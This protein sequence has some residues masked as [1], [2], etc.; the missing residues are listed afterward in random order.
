M[1][2]VWGLVCLGLLTL[3]PAELG[4]TAQQFQGLC[5]LVK[6]E[7][8]QELTLERIGFLATLEVTNNEGDAAITNFSAQLTFE[9]F[10]GGG[11]DASELFFVQPP[12]LQGINAIDGSGI[13]HPGE[14]A[15]VRWFIIPKIDAG[16]VTPLG[17]RY[18]VG[19]LLAGSIY[20]QEIAPEVLQVFPDIITVKPEPQLEI[21]YF[22]PRDVD[23]DDPFTTDVVEAPIPFTLGV[24]VNNVGFGRANDVKIASEQPKIVEN[25]QSLI[26]VAQLLGARVDDQP[27]DQTSLTLNLGDIESGNC[28]K[29]A[30]DMITSLSGEFIEFNASYTH[31]SELGGRDTSIIKDLNAYFISHEVLNDQPGRDGLKDFLADTI[32]DDEILPDTLFET[33][34]TTLPV[35]P[36][37][38]V[39]L[40]GST[41]LTATV[42]AVADFEGWVYMRLDDPKQAR[43]PIASVVRSDGKVLNPNN[44]WTNVRFEKSTNIKLTFLNIFDF[45]ALGEYTYE[46]TYEVPPADVDPP[47]TFLRFVGDVEER[48]GVFQIRPETQMYFTVEDASPVAIFY[49]FST[50]PDFLP[51]LPFFLAVPG[52]YEIEYF[53]IDAA[54]NE[55]GH[56]FA[57]L[58][59]S[60]VFPSVGNLALDTSQFFF[61]GDSVS[62]RSKEAVV[63]FD[64]G[65]PA[66]TVNGLIEVF[67]GVFGYATIEGV[68]SSPT[69]R[70]D[71]TIT[72][73]GR[74]VDFYRYSLNGAPWTA[75]EP[76]ANP[77]ALSGLSG[78]VELRVKGRSRY[79]DYRPDAEAVTATWTIAA[80]ADPIRIAG[81]Q[82]PSGSAGATLVVTGTPLYCYRVDGGFY[83]P[84]SSPG[85]QIVLSELDEGSHV[86]EVRAR[87]S[88]GDPCP[89]DVPGIAFSWTID[90][91]Y[92]TDLPAGQRVREEFLADIGGAPVRFTWDGLDENGAHVPPDWYT[93]KV[94]VTDSLSRATSDV[95]LVRVGDLLADSTAVA[96]VPGADQREAHASGDW[97]VWQDQRDGD[98]NVFAL[99]LSDPAAT[100]VRVT[101]DARNQERPRTDGRYVVWEDR[102]A[103]GSWDI[104][105]DDL[106][107]ATPPFPV[108]TTATLDERRPSVDWPW[109]VFQRR[110]VADPTAPWQ[111]AYVNLAT[112]ATGSVDPTTQNQL[113][114]VVRDGRA[115]WEDYRD[116]GAG[117]IYLVDLPSGAVRRITQDPGG[118]IQP[119]IDDQWIVW[120][121]NR[122]GLQLDLYGFNLK[123]GVE[124][125]LTD[126][127]QDEARPAA[128]A[129]WVVYTDDL[130]DG[131]NVDLRLL[132]L[133][134]LAS[135]QLTNFESEK[136]KPS[137]ASG[138]L[139]WVDKRSGDER[140][141]VGS[142]PDLQPVFDNNS[143]VVVTADMAA[144]HGDAFSLLEL[145]QAEAGVTQL[146]RFTNLLPTPVS[147]TASWS[148]S[149]TGDNFP[150]VPGS[151]LWV[152]FGDSE[153]LDLGHESCGA[154]DLAAGISALSYT[155]FPDRYTA[156][157]AIRE[158]GIANVN[159]IRVLDSSTGRWTVA[160]VSA[161]NLIGE[162]F[163]IPRV[164]VVL[165]DL[166]AAR[167]QWTPG[168]GN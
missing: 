73:A 126:T 86:V 51:A 46:I 106:T 113:A 95:A 160:S 31:A 130:A 63:R 38:D 91:S 103:D 82:T 67:R 55:E 1:R 157:Q 120:A 37:V 24:L 104:W 13:I 108:T 6:I 138:R 168:E 136:Q 16:G 78:T 26:L 101:I 122:A 61:T 8:L 45:V 128:N 152:E 40:I 147:E 28:R 68:P 74:N 165:L 15:V 75:E 153:I 58:D 36:L 41:S 142:V 88:A 107:D 109:V 80:G 14:T 114:P 57:T 77:I 115:V 110:A 17:V 161:G 29:G 18:S 105:A 112:L 123:R 132:Y 34:C 76:V 124:V 121:D 133:P 99:N 81:P 96:G 20:G 32:D 56:K 79:G 140:V 163:T 27:T 129:G 145:W 144:L 127:P 49:K 87:A 25:Q 141:M 85:A 59:L 72:V 166:K 33:D 148:A 149:A 42:R 35:N 47:E 5:A 143:A 134:S 53:S 151:F 64:P 150:L 158:L 44:Y 102:Q 117:E 50:D 60:S 66:T 21:T 159:A 43:Y 84:E 162:N 71:A 83:Q 118:Q 119:T 97:M 12:E 92:G 125:Q 23:G 98:W 155:C 111:L 164:T 116:P 137:L 69:Q 11:T 100:P 90:R 62:I 54:G 94:T 65:S 154:V 146:S 167:P 156:Y 4:R 135:L 139:V 52:V 3:A 19:A 70:T 89:G 10:D 9:D 2:A 22:Q 93:V 7:I 48:A 39:E 131:T 30:W